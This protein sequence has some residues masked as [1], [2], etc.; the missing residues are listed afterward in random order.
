[1][2]IIL[3]DSIK[4][5]Q[6]SRLVLNLKNNSQVSFSIKRFLLL[7]IKVILVALQL[8]KIGF[9][10]CVFHCKNIVLNFDNVL[11][12]PVKSINVSLYCFVSFSEVPF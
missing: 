5:W 12:K 3:A 1:M 9:L 2:S 4:T 8:L 7:L 10:G 6:P 11:V